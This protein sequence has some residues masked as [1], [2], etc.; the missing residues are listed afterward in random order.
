M[1]QKKAKSDRKM[2]KERQETFKRLMSTTLNIICQLELRTR[3]E[4]AFGIIFK[5]Y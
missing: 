4:L 2:S 5:K 3:I 1:N